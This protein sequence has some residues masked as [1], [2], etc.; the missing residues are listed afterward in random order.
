MLILASSSPRRQQLLKFITE[1][2][3]VESSDIEEVIDEEKVINHAIEELAYKKAREIFN[4]HPE[5]IV[6]GAD[7]V[8]VLAGEILGKPQDRIQ[9]ITM[10]EAL[11][12]KPHQVYT[13]VSIISKKASVNFHVITDVVFYPLEKKDIEDYVDEC[14]PFDKAGAYAIQEKAALFVKEIHG[15]YYNIMGLPIP[16]L[17]QELKRI[18]AINDA[19][20]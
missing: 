6:I 19:K 10:L 14:Q 4:K 7:T 9:A 8:V 13:G 16:R 5:A 17:N 3:T 20:K 1:D 18:Q 2:F 11:S 12:G 15:D